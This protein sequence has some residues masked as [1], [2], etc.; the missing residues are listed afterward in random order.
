MEFKPEGQ[1]EVYGL[2]ERV[3][4]HCHYSKLGRRERGVARF[5]LIKLTDLSQAQPT[6]LIGRWRQSRE[7]RPLAGAATKFCTAL[8]A[9]LRWRCGP[10]WTPRTRT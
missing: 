8:P 3:L 10:V 4:S 7:V 6:R 5:Y 1:S 9:L 2:I